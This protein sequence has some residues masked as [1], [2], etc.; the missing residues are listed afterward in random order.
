MVAP[1]WGLRPL[2]AFLCDTEKV[3]KPM[4]ATRSPFFRA[5]VMLST[6]VSMAD[7]ACDLLIR[8]PVAIRLIRSAL[9]I[10]SPGRFLLCSARAL[11]SA[12]AEWETRW[13]YLALVLLQ[14]QLWK[15]RAHW[16][17]C[18]P[19]SMTEMSRL[20]FC[21]SQEA[22]RG[23]R[24]RLSVKRKLDR[25]DSP[26]QDRCEL[27]RLNS[28]ILFVMQ[29]RL[30][31]Y[32]GCAASREP[33]RQKCDACQEE[34]HRYE[35]VGVVQTNSIKHAGREFSGSVRG[36]QT[37]RDGDCRQQH[38]LADEQALNCAAHLAPRSVQTERERLKPLCSAFGPVKV[39]RITGEMV[40]T[41][42]ADRK[43]ANVANKTI[44]LELGVL[45]GVMKRAKLWHHFSDDIKPLPVHTQIGR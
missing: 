3:P 6:A 22:R 41:Y 38:S 5:A 31:G 40:R 1:V 20:E 24:P 2:R 43:A 17:V 39:H 12:F 19:P 32:R 7:A 16:L 34:R 10:S 18:V 35:G 13:A 4:S 14:C 42:V 44:N 37:K 15:S 9:F 27:G 25:Y 21:V 29:D 36:G 30:R 11:G 33:A 8:L 28:A 23:S 26:S 45:R